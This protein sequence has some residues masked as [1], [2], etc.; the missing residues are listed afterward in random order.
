[1]RLALES[2]SRYINVLILFPHCRIPYT[3]CHGTGPFRHTKI[4]WARAQA[5]AL[6]VHLI[7]TRSTAK[8]EE[9]YPQTGSD[10]KLKTLFLHMP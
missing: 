9:Q 8:K 10:L 1:V 7:K 5:K 2:S 3:I 6:S 4:L